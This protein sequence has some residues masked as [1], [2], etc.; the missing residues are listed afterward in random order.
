MTNECNHTEIISRLST[1]EEWKN[2]ADRR[3]QKLEADNESLKELSILVRLQKES[4]DVMN[5]TLLKV[6]ESNNNISYEIQELK[7]DV[8]ILNVKVENIESTDNINLPQLIKKYGGVFLVAFVTG[9]AGY[10]LIKFG[11]K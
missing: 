2:S 7:E 1:L 6:S 4:L 5:K 3:T 11:L 8:T 9:L 10:A